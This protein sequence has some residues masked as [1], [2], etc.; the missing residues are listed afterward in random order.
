[1]KKNL[2]LLVLIHLFIFAT[3]FATIKT[4]T[5]Q[6]FSFTPANTSAFVGDTIKFQ[7]VGGSHTSTC[8]GTSGSTLPAGAASWNVTMS[9]AG[10]TFMYVLTTAGSYHFVCIPHS[11]SMAGNLTVTPATGVNTILSNIPESFSLNQNFPN[12]FNPSTKIKFN[13]AKAGLTKLSV[14]DLSGKEVST[15]VNENLSAGSY[16]VNFNAINISSGVYFYKLQ[17][18]GFTE[19]KKMTLLK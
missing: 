1:M 11:P 2:S 8:N 3:S 15:L 6:N 16:S 4:I 13:I 7:W 19:I 10:S 18:E 14:F 9:S 17:A 12:P 5:V